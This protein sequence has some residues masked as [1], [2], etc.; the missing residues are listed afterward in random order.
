MRV[1][2]LKLLY[3]NR[4]KIIYVNCG[5]KNYMKVDHRSYRRN[6]TFAVAKR[7]PE[8]KKFRLVRDSNPWPL[9]SFHNCK[10]CVYNCDDPL[11]YKYFYSSILLVGLKVCTEFWYTRAVKPCGENGGDARFLWLCCQNS[12]AQKQSGQLCRLRDFQSAELFFSPP[13]TTVCE[14]FLFSGEIPWTIIF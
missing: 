7:K 10:S 5:L 8:R 14:W 11:S 6:Y 2:L 4:M 9:L 1:F 13:T 3:M 12:Q